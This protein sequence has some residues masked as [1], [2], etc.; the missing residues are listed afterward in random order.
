MRKLNL[1]TW[2]RREHFEFFRTYDYPHFGMCA[3][4]ER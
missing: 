3:N 4:V 2:P 1:E